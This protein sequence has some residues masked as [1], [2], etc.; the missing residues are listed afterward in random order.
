MKEQERSEHVEAEIQAEL[1]SLKQKQQQHALAA[2]EDGWYVS[3]AVQNFNNR[4][5]EVLENK[6]VCWGRVLDGD[7][8]HKYRALFELELLVR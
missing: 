5:R 8:V 1:A 7:T 3:F 2:Q 6:L 4:Y